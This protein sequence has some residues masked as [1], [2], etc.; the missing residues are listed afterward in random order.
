M[1]STSNFEQ[2]K[3]LIQKEEK[4]IVVKAQNDEFNRKI[5]EYGR[6][7]ILLSVEKSNEKDKIKQ[8][9]SGLNEVLAKIAAKNKISIGIDLE[10]IC[11]LEKKEKAVLLARI[12]QNIKICRK[13]KCKIVFLN[14]KDKINAFEL[15]VSLGASTEQAKNAAEV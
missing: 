5:L 12:K 2:A 14:Y 4:P 1:I 7:D 11:Y 13:A 15:L 3:K 8:L 9:G 10:E 6:F